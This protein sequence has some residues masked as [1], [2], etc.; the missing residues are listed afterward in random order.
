MSVQYSQSP[1]GEQR[2]VRLCHS[3]ILTNH[4]LLLYSHTNL[5][6][7]GFFPPTASLYCL[8]S[9]QNNNLAVLI[10][11]MMNIW[12]KPVVTE[13][14]IIQLVWLLHV[15]AQNLINSTM[16][17]SWTG[18]HRPAHSGRCACDCSCRPVFRCGRGR[19]ELLL[20]SVSVAEPSFLLSSSAF[21]FSALVLNLSPWPVN[22]RQ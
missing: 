11:T 20:F 1:P 15:T 17:I 19:G 16:V 13:I 4:W 7:S 21:R 8:N 3:C 9:T 22:H 14:A 2:S 6:T 10:F 5:L 18:S 12:T